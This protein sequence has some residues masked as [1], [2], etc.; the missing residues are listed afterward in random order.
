[1]IHDLRIAERLVLDAMNDGEIDLVTRV[2][3]RQRE[4]NH[5]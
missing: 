2:R 4:E 1:V 5:K 3:G